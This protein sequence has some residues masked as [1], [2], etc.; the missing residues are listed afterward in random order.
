MVD[1]N[2]GSGP[3]LMRTYNFGSAVSNIS[4]NSSAGTS[5]AYIVGTADGKLYYLANE[6]DPT[7]SA[8]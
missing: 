8:N 2:N 3:A 1:Q 4:F 5:G 6:S 7:P